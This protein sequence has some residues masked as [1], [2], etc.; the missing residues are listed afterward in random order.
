MKN[1]I[2]LALLVSTLIF[3][4]SGC[5]IFSIA[6]KAAE[7]AAKKEDDTGTLTVQDSG[8][9]SEADKVKVPNEAEDESG[10]EN[11][12][13]DPDRALN[14]R[15]LT[16]GKKIYDLSTG[17]ELPLELSDSEKKVYAGGSEGIFFILVRNE[18]YNPDTSISQYVLYCLNA[19]DD[20]IFDTPLYLPENSYVSG[21]GAYE[22]RFYYDCNADERSIYFYD[23]EGDAFI[24]DEAMEAL[25]KELTEGL[26]CE[27]IAYAGIETDLACTGEI[28][29]W[30][31]DQNLIRTFD[32]EGKPLSRFSTGYSYDYPGDF[33]LT[34]GGFLIGDKIE[35]DEDYNFTKNHIDIYDTQKGSILCTYETGDKNAVPAI[36]D[37]RDG[38]VYYY[39][40]E[41]SENEKTIKRNYYRT[42]IDDIDL[43]GSPVNKLTEVVPTIGVWDYNN[44]GSGYPYDSIYDSYTVTKDACY[45]LEKSDDKK[46]AD[47]VW[48]RVAFDD[49]THKKISLDMKDSHIDYADYGYAKSR[50]NARYYEPTGDKCFSGYYEYFR[51]YEDGV[52]GIKNAAKMNE[53]LKGYDEA[54]ESYGE[55]IASNAKEEY[56]GIVS[57]PDY[58]PSEGRWLPEYSYER[59]F[60]GVEALGTHY[61]ELS[62]SDY[63]YWGGAHG[64]PGLSFYLFDT[65]TGS[66]ITLKDLYGGTE[67]DFKKTVAEYSVM[68]WKNSTEYR[69]YS[70]YETAIAED[71]DAEQKMYDEFY[72]S[73]YLD[74]LTTFA[75]DGI[76]IIYYPYDKGPYA[77]G[78]IDVFIPYGA[79]GFTFD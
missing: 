41:T 18:A 23:P 73:A 29:M 12:E 35:Y 77:S 69:Y 37:I 25:E 60:S 10:K 32:A 44:A 62:F 57:E 15:F 6:K 9:M 5:G 2:T 7:E 16:G 26:G 36:T 72:E 4:L 66:E 42:A 46:G 21:M 79:L 19:N 38:F 33:K 48:K 59:C 31:K 43:S 24:E 47:V 3:A 64:M 13:T 34:R 55:N 75:Q 76:Y 53:V 50:E 27:R 70:D 61:L 74:M 39:I 56:Y 17:K 22:G 45:F 40:T 68:D 78:F 63:E 67:E 71:P 52:S 65:D 54:A 49:E 20:S 11:T 51:F 1:K 8:E 58:D 14:D 28:Y 30:D